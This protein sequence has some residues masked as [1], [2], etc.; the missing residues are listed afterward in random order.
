L[1]LILYECQFDN[2]QS[3][4]KFQARPLLRERAR[5]GG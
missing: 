4:I 5:Q 2:H 1:A 3:V